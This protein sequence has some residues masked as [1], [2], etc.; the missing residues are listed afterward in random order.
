MLPTIELLAAELAAGRRSAVELTTAALGRAT[1][2]AGEGARVFT[3]IDAERAMAAASAS[4]TLRAAG[5]VRSPLEGLPVSVKDLFD[6]A[7]QPTTAGSVLL[8]DAPPAAR[9][10]VVI[11][12]LI[13][14]GAVIVGRTNM[15]EFAYSGLGL[16]PHYGTPRN[17]WDRATG[18]IPGGSSSGAAVSVSDGMAV[19]AV[20]SDT[21]G[22]VRIPSAL[23][24][25]TGFKPTARRVSMEGVLPLSTALDSIGPLAASVRCCA[26]MDAVLAGEPVDIPAAAELA[27]ASF[28][29]PTDVA[30]N[31][32]DETV[33]TAFEIA[34]ARLQAE[35]ARVRRIALPE[36]SQ[37]A[38]L[39]AR[40]TF[41]A[42]EAWAWH[43]GYLENRGAE[44]DPRVGSRIAV[45]AKMSAADLLDLMA[46]RRRWIAAVEARIAGFDALLMPTVPRIAP[47]IDLL[48]RDE[49]AYFAAN[50]LMLRNPTLINFLDGCALS[51]PCHDTGNAP[52]GLMIA[53][54]GG[55]DRRVLAL[56]QAIESVL[57]A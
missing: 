37:L 12:R 34:L 48:V 23:C 21:G 40:G 51:V 15:T 54:A 46:A 47:E 53:A 57:A 6:I 7:G 5:I 3:R 19:A 16:N 26:I 2:L 32:M 39:H 20:G 52:V 35:G 30:L 9:N 22:S 56:G 1:D 24:G 10:A 36:F 33:A 38:Q 13:A 14:A 29:V 49:Q 25:L 41:T 17:P 27:D 50:G 45:G 8:K 31:D 44:Y 42:A 4:D 43:R 18:R 11:D 55:S 28:A